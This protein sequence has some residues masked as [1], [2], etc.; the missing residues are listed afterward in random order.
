MQNRVRVVALQSA[1][2]GQLEGSPSK[3]P[4]AES[5]MSLASAPAL[6]PPRGTAVSMF[7]FNCKDAFAGIAP[8]TR[9]GELCTNFLGCFT[10]PNAI[11]TADAPSLARLLQ[12]RD[13]L[14]AANTYLHPARWAAIYA[15][16][17]RILEEDILTRF[18]ARELAA[19]APL[20]HTLP[21]LPQLR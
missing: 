18:S 12:A 2:L 15:P 9:A 10:C 19:G 16:Q 20:R 3:Q 1:F 21:P 17:L 7:G 13:H 11:I 5:I 6:T 8:G 4:L 14:R